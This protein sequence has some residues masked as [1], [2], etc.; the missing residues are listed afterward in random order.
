[1]LYNHCLSAVHNTQF[2]F[3]EEHTQV[4]TSHDLWNVLHHYAS[5]VYMLIMLHWNDLNLESST[6]GW[7][8]DSN[9]ASSLQVDAATRTSPVAQL[10]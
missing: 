7:Q 10:T 6:K 8:P 1:M 2:K 4:I 5:K 3:L 9:F